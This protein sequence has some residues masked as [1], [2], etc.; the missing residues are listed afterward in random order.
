M[1]RRRPFDLSGGPLTEQLKGFLKVWA[2]VVL[3]GAAWAARGSLLREAYPPDDLV[4]S[5]Q[6]VASA[7]DH[8]APGL[9]SDYSASSKRRAPRS[10]SSDRR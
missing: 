8:W 10:A 7:A 1:I 5:Q 9:R 2:L 3:L 4:E 6:V